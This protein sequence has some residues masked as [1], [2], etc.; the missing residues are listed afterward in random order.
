VAKKRKRK[1]TIRGS[2]LET[3]KKQQKASALLLEIIAKVPVG[4]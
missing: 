2:F 3:S 1:E 4:K